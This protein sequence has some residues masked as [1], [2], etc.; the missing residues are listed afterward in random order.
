MEKLRWNFPALGLIVL[1]CITI[2]HILKTVVSFSAITETVTL[3]L[4]HRVPRYET[5]LLKLHFFQQHL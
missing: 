3:R 2:P 4:L 1:L 5:V